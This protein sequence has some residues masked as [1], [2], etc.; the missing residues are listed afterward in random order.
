MSI[1]K[2]VY[3]VLHLENNCFCDICGLFTNKNAAEE[4]MKEKNK[5]SPNL[6]E[7]YYQVVKTELII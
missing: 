7:D 2:I 4:H 6:A 5:Y 3:V 1:S